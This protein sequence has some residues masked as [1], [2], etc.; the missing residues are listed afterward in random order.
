MKSYREKETLAAS[1]KLKYVVALRYAVHHHELEVHSQ[2]ELWP[3]ARI[4]MALS[5][6]D[7]CEA[8]SVAALRTKLISGQ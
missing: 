8:R 1:V 5:C 4:R 6:I 2:R 7:Q 3:G